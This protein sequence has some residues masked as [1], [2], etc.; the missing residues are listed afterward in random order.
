[1]RALMNKILNPIVKRLLH[2]PL[3]ILISRKVLLLTMRGR[4]TGNPIAVPAEYVQQGDGVTLI[5]LQKNKTWWKNVI[6]GAPVQVLLRG[7]TYAAYAKASTDAPTVEA[8]CARMY[9]WLPAERRKLWAQD[10]VA[11]MIKLHTGEQ[12]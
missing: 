11:V 12:A 9:P 6:D 4:K 3:H 5:S 7:K 2:T 8:G 1:M 10:R